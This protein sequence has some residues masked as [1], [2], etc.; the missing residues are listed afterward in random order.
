EQ[1]T[2]TYSS[3]RQRVLYWLYSNTTE[4]FAGEERAYRHRI[5][6]W[7]LLTFEEKD[8]LSHFST[9]ALLEPFFPG[10]EQ[11]ERNWSPLWRIY[12]RRWDNAGNNASTFLWNLYWKERRGDDLRFELFPL[13][14]YRDE[15]SLQ[16]F[17]LSL[18][19]G[20][21][22]YTRD[23]EQSCFYLLYLPWGWCHPFADKAPLKELP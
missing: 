16:R 6:L 23:P 17:E 3:Q 1:T 8:G 14:H 4:Q 12:Q 9:L 22:R 15:E 20:L 21:Y 7:P 11:I 18:L 10:N 19:K 13:I 5:D 2:P